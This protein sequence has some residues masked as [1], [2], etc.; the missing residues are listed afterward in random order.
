[1]TFCRN[2]QPEVV[3]SSIRQ[4][5]G[6]AK[7]W[8]NNI[9]HHKRDIIFAP[10]MQQIELPYATLS[11]GAPIVDITYKR[12]A[13]LG[14]IEIRELIATAQRLSDGKP[15]VVLSDVRQGIEVT[16]LG[17]KVVS[18]PAEAPLHRGTAILFEERDDG[19][20]RQFY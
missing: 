18:D 14:F 7:N 13:Q 12:N 1:M 3:L 15:Y 4:A 8:L 2:G 16:P 11:Y 19:A 9:A 20:C 10:S 17:R 5:A 6:G